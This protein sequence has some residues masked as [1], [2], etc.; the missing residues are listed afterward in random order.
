MQ[1][2][3]S[4]ATITCGFVGLTSAA[5]RA[6]RFKRNVRGITAILAILV[7]NRVWFLHSSLN[8]ECLRKK[9]LFHHYR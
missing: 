5:I 7:L 4:Q 9:L 6:S 2:C 1:F 8:W 3:S